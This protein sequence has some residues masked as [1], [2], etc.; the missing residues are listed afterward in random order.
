[1]KKS[2]G[3]NSKFLHTYLF[4]HWKKVLAAFFCSLLLCLSSCCLAYLIGP[5]LTFVLQ[6]KKDFYHLEELFG[7]QLSFVI[8]FF[9]TLD[10]IAKNTL[11]EYL[12]F[13]LII[14]ALLKALTSIVQAFL[15]EVIG[16]KIAFDIRVK[17]F[18]LYILSHPHRKP[19][20]EESGFEKN[21]ATLITT[22]IKLFRDYLV[23]VWG[24]VSRELIQVLGLSLGL[25]FLSPILFFSF[26]FCL[27][28]VFYLL[29]KIGK[30]LSRRSSDAI[31]GYSLLSEWLQERFLGLETIKA[32]RTEG[33]EIKKMKKLNQELF[34]K[35]YKLAYTES[36]TGP[37]L[38]MAAV[39]AL[40]VVLFVALSLIQKELIT[41]SVAFSF[42]A[43]IAILSQSINKL[44]RYFNRN[45]ASI[46][47]KRRIFKYL[48]IFEESHTKIYSPPQVLKTD[49][50]GE[51]L[52]CQELSFFY[53][54]R[55][56]SG[57]K[58]FSHS[59]L[60]GKFYCITGPS[61]CGKSTLLKCLLGLLP[62]H[63]GEVYYHY[64]LLPLHKIAYI[65][66]KI[67]MPPLS[68]AECVSYPEETFDE[69]KLVNALKKVNFYDFIQ[70]LDKGFNTIL[71]DEMS[72][73]FSGGQNQ[74]L[75]LARLFYHDYPLI[76]IDEGTASLDPLSED[77]FCQNLLELVKKTQTTV[78]FVSHSQTVMQ[79]ADDVI[80]MT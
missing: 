14:F 79:Y 64:N 53:K 41:S 78:L 62:F 80:Y 23:N 16:E 26:I 58:N 45:K 13:F 74:K 66:Q 48:K 73:G 32:R 46:G 77:K 10:P 3:D 61:G 17:F 34:D 30:K 8:K 76:L 27:L 22:D 60:K 18:S 28:P 4:S 65:S 40:I 38:E 19:Q 57:V 71:G 50:N 51:L 47:S 56:A 7:A 63:K 54:K 67:S 37:L 5:S 59:F 44:G 35:H 39:C 24:S 6:E 12:V 72:T 68:L 33:Y 55:F 25:I 42:F 15:W 9:F 52:V 36:R 31:A 20:F 2:P 11:L 75:L 49:N 21:I 69:E 43:V 29:K 70:S 1:M